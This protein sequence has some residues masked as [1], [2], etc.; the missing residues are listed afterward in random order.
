VGVGM[1]IVAAGDQS[2]GAAGPRSGKSP[3]ARRGCGVCDRPP[4]A[5]KDLAAWASAS[6]SLRQAMGYRSGW[7]PERMPGSSPSRGMLKGKYNGIATEI[8]LPNIDAAFTGH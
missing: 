8:P 5:G 4:V 6:G 1:G 7:A 2:I 3:G